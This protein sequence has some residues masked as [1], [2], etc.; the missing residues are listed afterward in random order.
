MSDQMLLTFHDVAVTF[1]EE[2]WQLLED[3]QKD[4]YRNVMKE[5]YDNLLSLMPVT[6]HDIAICFSEEE[7]QLLGE[8]QKA[9]Y[10][11]VMKENYDI[12]ISLAGRRTPHKLVGSSSNTRYQEALFW[13]HPNQL[14]SILKK[15]SLW[16]IPSALKNGSF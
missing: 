12:L 3:W 4:L 7:W 6:F 11:N 15:C 2:E 5:T 8:H 14:Y 13:L 16:Y 10:R 9:L 1:S